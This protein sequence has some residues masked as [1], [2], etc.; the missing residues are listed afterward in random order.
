MSPP[1]HLVMP[2]KPSPSQ[3]HLTNSPTFPLASVN[4]DESSPTTSA[5][6][7]LPGFIVNPNMPTLITSKVEHLYY[8]KEILIKFQK[9]VQACFYRDLSALDRY[10]K[11]GIVEE[12]ANNHDVCNVLRSI[13]FH[14]F[15]NHCISLIN[16]S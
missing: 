2:M 15:I 16:F 5:L 6:E 8:Y 10:R 3:S 12:Y 1:P 4:A 13:T 11:P 7:I 9:Y 14:D